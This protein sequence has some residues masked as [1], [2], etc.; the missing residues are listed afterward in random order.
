MMMGGMNTYYLAFWLAL[1]WIESAATRPA[2][3]QSAPTPPGK[4]VD[5]GG[6]RVHLYCT[7]RVGEKDESMLLR[8][9]WLW[10]ERP[11]P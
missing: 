1:S 4:L 11:R 9:R 10:L 7:G 5:V 8:S 2:Q 3:D 6:R